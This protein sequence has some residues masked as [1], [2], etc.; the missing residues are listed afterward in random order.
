LIE[1]GYRKRL[2]DGIAYHKASAPISISRVSI[3]DEIRERVM[4][5]SNAVT[6]A[7]PDIHSLPARLCHDIASGSWF[8]DTTRSWAQMR[9][10]E[11]VM[12]S[13]EFLEFVEECLDW[14]KAARSGDERNIF[15]Q[16]AQAWLDAARRSE[17]GPTRLHRARHDVVARLAQA[18]RTIR[19]V[20]PAPNGRHCRRDTSRRSAVSK[21]SE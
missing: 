1:H 6:A 21:A 18:E 8:D 17:A 14:A 2:G 20:R 10:W 12:P 11:R 7:F 9:H 3:A 4:L 16:M 19:R 5:G 13:N 15:L